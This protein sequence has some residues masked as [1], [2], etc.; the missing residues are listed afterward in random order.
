MTIRMRSSGSKPKDG[1]GSITFEGNLE[2]IENI[3]NALTTGTYWIRKDDED[4]IIF[5]S[6]YK[7]PAKLE[8]HDIN[9]YFKKGTIR[10]LTK[11]L[12]KKDDTSSD[13]SCSFFVQHLGGYGDYYS[14]NISQMENA[15]FECLRS[16]RGKD[17]KYWEIWY[18]PGLWA[19]K[20]PLEK[21]K[22]KREVIKFLSQLGVGQFEVATE[23]WG[24]ALD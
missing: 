14:K 17:G 5:V 10:R 20:G 9:P 6:A 19:G 12:L 11:G 23:H 15:G 4:N 2:E 16:R 1:T 13:Q 24:L 22:T 3:E 8:D 21:V 18:L 7:P